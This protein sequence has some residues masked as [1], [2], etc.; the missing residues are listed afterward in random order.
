MLAIALI[1]VVGLTDLATGYEMAFSIYYVFP[2]AVAAWYGG[3][4]S[5]L[6]LCILCAVTWL[7][8]DIA[9]GHEFRV[10]AMRYRGA[11]VRLAYFLIIAQLLVRLREAMER[12]QSLAQTDGLT[13]LLNARAFR[14]QCKSMFEFGA[15]HRHAITVGYV[16][17]DGFK[18]INDRLGHD[19]GDAV[20]KSFAAILARRL[21][22]TDL[23]CRMGGDEFVVVL[24]HTDMAGAQRFFSELR[25][26]VVN[27]A[28]Q[29]DWPIGVSMGV[30][31]FQV[32]TLDAGR[33]I[34]LAD[35]L[36]YRVKKSGKNR[37]LIEV[38][39]AQAQAQG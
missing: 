7:G 1:P 26:G 29:R 37:T 16:D 36:M 27:M 22:S 20:L 12:Q 34:A 33:A 38:V 10:E 32:P 11:G 2:I 4:R 15:R 31:V 18:V 5:G 9:S 39:S 23:A 17:L 13:G 21:R 25:A 24:P 35:G 30:A 28:L 3:Q 14:L 8:V 19:T 6:L